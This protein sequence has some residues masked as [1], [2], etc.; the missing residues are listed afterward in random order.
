M[1]DSASSLEFHIPGADRSE[2]PETLTDEVLSDFENQKSPQ[3]Y[4]AL[5]RSGRFLSVW[6]RKHSNFDDPKGKYLTLGLRYD[7][8]VCGFVGRVI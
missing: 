7:A 2:I 3:C 1:V 8:Y 4:F 6:T 5:F